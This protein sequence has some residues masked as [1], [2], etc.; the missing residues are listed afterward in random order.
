[1]SLEKSILNGNE[2]RKQFRK[3]KSFD[4]SCRN[5]QGCPQCKG[6]R[7]HQ[8]NKEKERIRSFDYD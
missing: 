8:V 3:S 7:M 5:N 6:N 4:S 2:H 1:M